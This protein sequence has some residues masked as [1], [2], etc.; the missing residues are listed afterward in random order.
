MLVMLEPKVA[1]EEEVAGAM[2]ATVELVSNGMPQ[3][4]LMVPVVAV[5]AVE[6]GSVVLV[7]SMAVELVVFFMVV[8]EVV[9]K[10]LLLSFTPRRKLGSFVCMECVSMVSGCS[11]TPLITMSRVTLDMKNCPRDFIVL[12]GRKSDP[13]S[14]LWVFYRTRCLA[15]LTLHFVVSIF[16][17]LTKS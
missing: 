9:P 4:H 13:F 1:V 6:S 17:T 14:V 12:Y 8:M 11:N 2:V 3:T 7:V 15:Q 16:A 5:E 10:V